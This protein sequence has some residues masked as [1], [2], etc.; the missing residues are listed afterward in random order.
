MTAMQGLSTLSLSNIERHLR[1]ARIEHVLLG[2]QNGVLH[3][4]LITDR[5]HPELGQRL[6]LVVSD[7]KEICVGTFAVLSIAEAREA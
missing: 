6:S 4:V 1:G 2:P 3:L 7:P 5:I